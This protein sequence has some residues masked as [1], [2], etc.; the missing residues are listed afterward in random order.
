MNA[1][2][3]SPADIRSAIS[4]EAW[5]V[6]A[7]M[8]GLPVEGPPAAPFEASTVAFCVALSRELL[9]SRD[10]RAHPQIVALGYWLRAASI[11]RAREAFFA[12]EDAHT[13]LVPRG[14]VFHV[15]P[16]N[17][18]TVFVYSWILALLVGN[19]NVVRLS[20]RVT[21]ST[22]RLLDS[23]ARVICDPDFADVRKRNHL[24]FTGHDDR[25]SKALSSAA[26][27]RVLWG[28]D[29]TIEHFRAFELPVRGRD[30]TFPNRHSLAIIDEDAIR[31]A[32][33][34]DLASLADRFFNDA[35]WFDQGACSSPR[36]VVWQTS[37]S[38]GADD[39]RRRFKVAVSEAIRRRSYQSETGTAIE[40]MVFGYR[41]AAVGDG[42]RYERESNEATWVEI[43][44]LGMYDRANCGGGLFFEFVSHD[45]EAD[46]PALVRVEDQTAACFGIDEAF[47]R[48]LARRL[49]GRG[50]DRWVPIGRALEFGRVWDGYDLLQEFAKRV[51]VD[52]PARSG[53]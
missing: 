22:S 43:P 8:R 51:V 42:V 11:E 4:N 48:A 27:V 33:E 20:A 25:I 3:D 52:L 21:D 28:G 30:V 39:T 32:S 26:D 34:E 18:D 23:I 24:I 1:L 6:E 40:K 38:D 45:L 50:I 7:F 12:N 14:R 37:R 36:L 29:A 31:A 17:I 5:T 35:Y 15:T 49:N 53:T 46:L 19:S 10:A 44:D 9:T 16:A 13:F 2:P 41:R 47:A